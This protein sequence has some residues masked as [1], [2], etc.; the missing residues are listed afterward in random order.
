V[1]A[2]LTLID[3]NTWQSR[4]LDECA[5]DVS[6]TGQEGVLLA[7]GVLWNSA[8]QKEIGCGLTGYAVDGTRRYHVFGEQPIWIAALAGTYAYVRSEDLRVHRVVDTTT[9]KLL[10]TVR[11]AKPTTIAPTQTVS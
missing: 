4:R 5:A 3:T 8:T 10:A 6:Y 11:T 7:H 9:G 2:G 1:A